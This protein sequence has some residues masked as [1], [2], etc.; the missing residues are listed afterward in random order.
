M[1]VARE[2]RFQQSCV[3]IAAIMLIIGG[4]KIGAS[5]VVPILLAAFIAI[6]FATP[7]HLLTSWGVPKVV[8]VMGVLLTVIVLSILLLTFA[9]NSLQEF[10][11]DFPVY[12]ARMMDDHQR[13]REWVQQV[14]GENLD[15]DYLSPRTG[16]E[17]VSSSLNSLGNLFASSFLVLLI[18][19]FMLFE[20]AEIPAK[21]AA[22]SQVDPEWKRPL[23]SAE[24]I[25]HEIRHYMVIKTL[26]GLLTGSSI[27]IWLALLNIKFWFLWGVITFLMNFIP[28][29]GAILAAIPAVLIAY[30]QLGAQPAG[31][32]AVGFVVVN[33]F[34][35]YAVEPRV[36]GRGLDMSTLVVFLSLVFWGWVLG[37]VGMLLSVPLT[38]IVKIIALNFEET[39]WIAILLGSGQAL[40]ER[41]ATLPEKEAAE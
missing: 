25:I 37:P 18:V 28:N 6:I 20:S 3:T 30:V 5:I 39:T 22:V 29:I 9:G 2:S 35:G 4:L 24:E 36:L 26:V 10:L 17:F 8:A 13:L 12:R 38:M 14:A 23:A 27:A 11:V 21:L 33:L 31:F 16:L 1:S 41:V 32:A 34:Y 40:E 19:I 7:I 15:L